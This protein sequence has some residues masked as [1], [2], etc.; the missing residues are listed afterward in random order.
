[1]LRGDLIDSETRGALLAVARVVLPGRRGSLADQV[2]RLHPTPVAPLRL[3]RRAPVPAPGLPGPDADSARELE[4][5][6]GI[7]GFAA[8]GR[9]YYHQRGAAT[10]APW[11]NVIANR[12]FGFH[13]SAEGAGFTWSR[14]SR[15]NALTPWSNDPVTDR[16]GEAIYLRDEESG[17]LWSPTPAPIRIENAHYSCTHGFGYTRFLQR[18]HGVVTRTHAHGRGG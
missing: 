15:E 11:I 8:Q 3:P 7:G 9:E 4:F 17:E 12:G 16:P 1:M 18:S 14:N 6:N 5:F 2:E 10:P 13:V